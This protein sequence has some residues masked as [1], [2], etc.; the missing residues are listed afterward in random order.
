M[1]DKLTQL[2]KV[3]EQDT[4]TVEELQKAK[5]IYVTIAKEDHK[6]GEY[7]D[8]NFARSI[9]SNKFMEWVSENKEYLED[10]LKTVWIE[11]RKYNAS[12]ADVNEETGE[13][14][15]VLNIRLGL[16]QAKKLVK[17]N[18]FYLNQG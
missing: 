7:I 17:E 12:I 5:E 13:L 11:G 8:S 2:Q 18:D 4:I 6:Q 9:L 16:K 14:D 15:K 1:A 3:F 10:K